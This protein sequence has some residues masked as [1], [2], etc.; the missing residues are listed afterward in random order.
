MKTITIRLEDNLFKMLSEVD[1]KP[2]TAAQNIVELF[3]YLRR[4]TLLELKGRFTEQEITVLADIYNGVMPVWKYLANNSMLIAEIED[5]EHLEGTCSRHGADFK[6]L[7]EKIKGLTSA[8]VAILQLEL[9]RFWNV[10]GDGGYGSPSPD[11][12]KLIKFLT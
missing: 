6:I 12:N 1:Y 2:T 7:I 8:Q 10:E 5:A 11:L 3:A 4:T 9:Y